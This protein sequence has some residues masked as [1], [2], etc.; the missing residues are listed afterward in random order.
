MPQ[1]KACSG[2]GFGHY[3]KAG[4]KNPNLTLH[5]AIARRDAAQAVIDRLT[6]A[7]SSGQSPQTAQPT[8]RHQSASDPETE[9]VHTPDDS[10]KRVVVKFFFEQLGCP[11]EEDW[12]GRYGTIALIRQRMGS[13]APCPATVRRTLL[14]LVEGDE[15]VAATRRGGTG[16]PRA[17]TEVDDLYI[18]LLACEGMSQR[19]VVS[20]V[21]PWRSR[22]WAKCGRKSCVQRQR[23]GVGCEMVWGRSVV[24]C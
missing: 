20:I 17:L 6:N 15:D 2:K 18:G 8:Q 1:R 21:R 12:S 23:A 11:P 13:S 5:R 16:R 24:R 10:E 3:K 22:H 14:R 9:H 4:S 7:N 19:A